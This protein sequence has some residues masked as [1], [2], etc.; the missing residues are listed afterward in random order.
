MKNISRDEKDIFEVS[1]KE[2]EEMASDDCLVAQVALAGKEWTPAVEKNGDGFIFHVLDDGTPC[3]DC[4]H[5]QSGSC[6][7]YEPRFYQKDDKKKIAANRKP[8]NNFKITISRYG[9]GIS[10]VQHKNGDYTIC[11]YSESYQS[12]YWCIFLYYDSINNAIVQRTDTLEQALSWIANK[13]DC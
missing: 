13:E 2:A 7:C 11:Q 10:P 6:L 12:F 9:K 4:I 3:I 5:P 1:R 8:K